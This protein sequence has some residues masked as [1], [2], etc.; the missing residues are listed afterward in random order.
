MADGT[1]R[2]AAVVAETIE[3]VV[4]GILSE[5]AD[6]YTDLGTLQRGLVERVE[7]AKYAR[8]A[9]LD[10]TI[11]LN[12]A[13]IGLGLEEITYRP[14]DFAGLFY[15]LSGE[16]LDADATTVLF[17]GGQAVTFAD[18]HGDI[19]RAERH[20]ADSLTD[21][22]FLED[23]DVDREDIIRLG[24]RHS[25]P[26]GKARPNHDVPN[27]DVASGREGVEIDPGGSDDS[28]EV[29]D[30]EASQP[31]PDPDD[32]VDLEA[33]VD[34]DPDRGDSATPT[35]DVTSSPFA[36]MD[37][38]SRPAV[39]SGPSSGDDPALEPGDFAYL[40]L[41]V[42]YPT[43]EPAGVTSRR[44]PDDQAQIGRGDLRESMAVLVGSEKVPSVLSE[45]LVGSAVG[46]RGQFELHDDGVATAP[47]PLTAVF[48]AP[49]AAAFE[50]IDVTTAWAFVDAAPETLADQLR[51]DVDRLR[52]FQA[53]VANVLDDR[54][55]VGYEVV[56]AVRWRAHAAPEPDEHGDDE[57]GEQSTV[58][59]TAARPAIGTTD[60]RMF[61]GG[62]AR[63]GRTGAAA[64]PSG[65][66]VAWQRDFDGAV[67]SSP[68]VADGLVFVGC[69]D[70]S[71]Y[72]CNLETGTPVW[73]HGTAGEVRSSP[74]VADG[75]VVVGSDAGGVHA[76]DAETGQLRWR[77][78][79]GG[80]VVSSPAVVGD[81]VY[82]GST[83]SCVYAIDFDTGDRLWTHETDGAVRSSPAVSPDGE[84]V[85]VGG[86]DGRMYALSAGDGSRR[87]TH[88]ADRG[89]YA[90]P[91]VHAD[92]SSD[93]T[94]VF[95]GGRDETLYA[96]DA[97][98]GRDRWTRH[99]G[100]MRSSPAVADGTVFVG[101]DDHY[102]YAFDAGSGEQ[103]WSL[104]T[105]NYVQSSP[106]VAVGADPSVVVV[107]SWDGTVYAVDAATG[108]VAWEFDVG[109]KVRAS[110]AV[111]DGTVLAANSDGRL[112]ALTAAGD[113]G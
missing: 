107:G 43:T 111:V 112:Y 49:I 10:G 61:Q 98:T 95:I 12:A 85:Y 83:D 38:R 63:T 101:S 66:T 39:P 7:S 24:D 68:A 84:A 113:G 71:L 58:R 30:S 40:S 103:Q 29:T 76:L 8:K 5:F 53:E 41:T 82:L 13:A 56:D 20:L 6:E 94:T 92:D 48:D 80:E 109:G 72:A 25:T 45:Q 14:D 91:A 26:E 64:P 102:L 31:S 46:A 93:G 1:E 54:V 106:A 87:W 89:V 4:P 78:Q 50:R 47:T 62:P 99:V 75:T 23:D 51:R 27:A 74:A 42:R 96:L 79:T 81:T 105:G 3:S 104:R 34:P 55:L 33:F 65:V 110:P 86:F 44:S 11:S 100:W 52:Q 57:S 32:Y 17:G 18:S 60:W 70:G 35:F 97:A 9:D 19:R 28:A 108:D 15:R 37:H 2:D 73:S 90:T 21:L 59:S 36:D 22:G 69:R 16:E 67:H 88:E 77:T